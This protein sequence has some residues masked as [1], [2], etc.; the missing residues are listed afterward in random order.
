[1]I[2]VTQMTRSLAT[3]EREC[4]ETVNIADEISERIRMDL[5]PAAKT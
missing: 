1:M 5:N 2:S 3:S 4:P